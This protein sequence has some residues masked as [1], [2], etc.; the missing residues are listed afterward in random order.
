MGFK[1]RRVVIQCMLLRDHF[2]C[3]VEMGCSGSTFMQLRETQLCLLQ[4]FK[5]NI[6]WSQPDKGYSKNLVLALS[7][8][9]KDDDIYRVWARSFWASSLRHMTGGLRR[10]HPC[11]HSEIHA[12]PSCHFLFCPSLEWTDTAQHSSNDTWP[13]PTYAKHSDDWEEQN[14][15]QS[16]LSSREHITDRNYHQ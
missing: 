7:W 16:V 3:H 8:E 6:Y 13:V 1:Q 15:L 12:I 14:L 11:A 10:R 5:I 2:G 9:G 4:C